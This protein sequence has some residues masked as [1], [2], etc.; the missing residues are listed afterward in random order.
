MADR[1]TDEDW[2]EWEKLAPKL[3]AALSEY[4]TKYCHAPYKPMSK[5]KRKSAARMKV[6]R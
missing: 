4:E 3:E 2:R 5:R 1:M 6:K